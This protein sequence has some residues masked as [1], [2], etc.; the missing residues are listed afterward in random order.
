MGMTPDRFDPQRYAGV[1]RPAMEAETLPPWCYTSPE[2]YA[3]E[4][5]RIFL[6]VWNFIGRADQIPDPGDYFALDFAGVPV[7]VV[8]DRAGEVRAFANTCRH[9]GTLLVEGE[10]NCRAFKCPYHSWVYSLEGE[11]LGAP[12]MQ[13]TKNFDPSRYGLIPIK[14]ETWD[15]FLFINFDPGSASLREYLGDLPGKLASYDF[16]EM[17][18]VRRKRYDLACNW[19]IYVE[20]AMEALHVA[21]VHKSTI[22]KQKRTM[23][24]PEV[25]GGE[26]VI[27]YTAHEGSRALLPG[28][29]G[30][31]RIETLAGKPAG[32]SY[33]PLIYPSTMFGCTIDCMWY[34]E[35]HPRGPGRTELIVGSCF[36]KKTVARPDFEEMI[37]RYYKRWDISIPEDNAISEWQQRG[38]E[39]PLCAPGRFSHLE[40]LVHAIDNWVLDRAIGPAAW[41]PAYAER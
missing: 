3:R 29:T 20:N 6:K 13:E 17:V 32:G 31:P 33:Y 22:Q 39:S 26:Y 30:F 25:P 10:G 21:T 15:G 11:L 18:C 5:E 34:L 36:P 19:K 23:A 7:I 27:L 38:L 14:L 4:V 35:L 28:D 8:R 37:T 41:A 12:E 2:F 40:P 9:R 1:R 24:E 16:S